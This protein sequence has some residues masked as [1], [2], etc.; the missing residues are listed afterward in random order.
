VTCVLT[1]ASLM[2]RS[3]AISALDRPRVINRSTA[4]LLA[5]PPRYEAALRRVQWIGFPAG[6]AGAAVL[7]LALYAAQLGLSAAWMRSHAYGPVEWLLRAAT[8]LRWPAWRRPA[9]VK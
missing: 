6:L 4:A 8:R 9:G 5:D 1:V 2:N 3:P 7:C